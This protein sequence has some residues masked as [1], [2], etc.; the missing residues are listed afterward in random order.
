MLGSLVGTFGILPEGLSP[1]ETEG[2]NV[3]P[4]T[5]PLSDIQSDTEQMKNIL[6]HEIVEDKVRVLKG[7]TRRIISFQSAV[8]F[9]PDGVEIIPEM[10][11]TLRDMAKILSKSDY[12]IIIEGHTDDQ[13]PQNEALLNNWYVSATRAANILRFFIDEGGI[14]PNRLSAFGY[15]GYSPIVVNNSPENRTRN[16]RIDIVLDTSYLQEASQFR[17]KSWK[18]KPV[19][20]RGFSFDLFGGK[21]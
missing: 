13:P 15:A 18:P 1:F 20:F 8:F 10:E 6:G 5:S 7:R 17:K 14:D 11:E 21:E 2:R 9:P 3:A 4:Q 12:K 19:M 16:R